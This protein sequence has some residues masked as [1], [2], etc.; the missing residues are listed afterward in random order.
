MFI[1]KRK[2]GDIVL[3]VHAQPKSSRNCVAGLHDE[4]VKVCVTSPPADNKA[5]KAIKHFLA[6]FFQLAKKDVQLVTGGTSRKKKFVL[7]DVS[8]EEVRKRVLRE[9]QKEKKQ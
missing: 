5:N 9:I 1:E 3:K 8:E 2:N 4:S 6:S 7:N